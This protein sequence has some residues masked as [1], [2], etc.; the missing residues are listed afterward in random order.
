MF[1]KELDKNIVK[2]DTDSYQQE[3]PEKLHPPLQIG[4]IKDNIAHQEKTDGKTDK[5]SNDKS[6]NMR[7]HRYRAKVHNLLVEQKVVTDKIDDD[8]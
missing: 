6:H 1:Y 2:D 3:I 5:K 4:I 8:V 7:T